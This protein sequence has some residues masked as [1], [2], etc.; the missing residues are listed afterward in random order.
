[1]NKSPE[2]QPD[3]AYVL[4][5]PV[6]LP[7]VLDILIVGGGPAGTAAAFRAKEMGIS[8]LVIDLDD[9]M[10][11]IRDYAKGKPI[12]PDYGG[13]DAMRFPKGGE[14]VSL[15]HFMEIDKDDMHQLWKS[16]YCE[17]SIPAQVGVEFAGMSRRK[18]GVWQ[19]T[20]WNH[21]TNSEQVFLARHII[22]A[23]GRG[24]PRRFD[25]PGNT[26][27]IAYRLNDPDDFVGEPACVVGGGTSAAEAVIAISEAKAAAGDATA[28][29]WSYRGDKMPRVSKALADEFFQ[30]YIGNGNILYHPRSEPAAVVI[31]EDNLEY[32]AIRTDRK[33]IEGRPNESAHL[34]FLKPF[35]VACIGEDIPEK[36]LND[37]GIPMVTGGPANKKRMLVSPHLETVQEN[38]YYAGDILSQAYLRA[39]NFEA[40]PKAFDE[41][42]HRGNIKAALVDG[43]LIVNVIAQKLAGKQEIKV[44]LEWAEPPAEDARPAPVSAGQV[45]SE[46]P[47]EEAIAGE[48]RV[49]EAPGRLVRILPGNVEGD[50]YLV[51]RNGITT[52][53]RK[54]CDIT[55]EEDTY[56]SDKHASISHTADGTFLRD[57]GSSNGV[58]L[59]APEGRPLEMIP[60]NLVRAGRQFL[61]ISKSNGTYQF[62]HYDQTGKE[63]QRW[64]I[65]EGTM[66]LG[67]DA[68]DIILDENDKTLS[69]RQLTLSV[70][71]NKLYIKD[72]KSVNGTWLKIKNARKLEHGD[73][74][75]VGQQTFVFSLQDDAA[76]DEGHAVES[77]PALPPAPQEAPPAGRAEAPAVKPGELAVTFKNVGKTFALKKGQTICELAEEHGLTINAE[78]HAGICGSDPLRIIS[79][80]DHFNEIGPEEKEALEDICGLAPGTHRL[81]CMAIPNRPVEIEIITG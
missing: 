7:E 28:V 2:I 32:L 67:R 8:A 6:K 4:E 22:M 78:C 63:V 21:N 41:I 53:G 69:R 47:P 79:G 48:R 55:L 61:L 27:G 29:Y 35:C 73:R 14:L 46:G 51:K 59:R 10:R 33:R 75:R 80:A 50:E 23:I 18:D 37:I 57:D 39:Q 5:T 15:L 9:I 62:A 19:V 38:V 16:F 70:K 11:R 64:D 3:G 30:S 60:G 76:L 25:I 66:V 56:L 26:M 71:E 68:P 24:F 49:E 74:F 65:P 12:K 58:F 77:T 43:V 45:E 81:A 36:F 54:G 52:I 17:H 72:L 1:M 31:A 44:E 40:D 13:G 34:E 20:C 42:K